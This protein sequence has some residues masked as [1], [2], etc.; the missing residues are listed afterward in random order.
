MIFF[1][2]F[3]R[4]FVSFIM[5]TVTSGSKYP[6]EVSMFYYSFKVLSK[7]LVNPHSLKEEGEVK[8]ETLKVTPIFPKSFE[9]LGLMRFYPPLSLPPLICLTCGAL[10]PLLSVSIGGIN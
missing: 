2:Y 10:P 1:P 5:C 9:F 8:E 3:G 6:G 4:N 7:F